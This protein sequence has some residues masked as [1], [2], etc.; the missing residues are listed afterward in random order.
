MKRIVI[1]IV[2]CLMSCEPREVLWV[3]S[4]EDFMIIGINPP[5]HFYLDLKRVRDGMVFTHV[6]VSKHC[7]DW[8]RCIYIGSIIPAVLGKYKQGDSVWYDF[9]NLAIYEVVC[10]C[11]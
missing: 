1:F 9:D 11:R 6:Y 5:K 4:P 10:H 7:N 2:L 3:N 8:E